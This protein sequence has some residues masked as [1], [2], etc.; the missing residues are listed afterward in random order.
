MVTNGARPVT[1][2]EG[3]DSVCMT[4]GSTDVETGAGADRVDAT[5]AAVGVTADL[6]GGSDIFLGSAASDLVRAGDEDDAQALLPW[7]VDDIDTGA[8]PDAVV[9]GTVI[10]PAQ[11]NGDSVRLGDDA[12]SVTVRGSVPAVLGGGA[13]R[14][15]I[16]PESRVRGDWVVDARTG[17]ISLEGV[18]MPAV[19]SFSTWT[20]TGLSWDTLSFRGGPDKDVVDVTRGNGVVKDGPF[21]ARMGPGKDTIYARSRDT[22][23]FNGGPGDDTL[24]I[25]AKGT[26]QQGGK[27]IAADLAS[28]SFKLTGYDKVRIPSI[29]NLSVSNTDGARLRRRRAPQPAEDLRLRQRRLRHGRRRPHRG[30]G[31]QELLRLRRSGHRR[32]RQRR[33]RQSARQHQPGPPDRRPRPGQGGRR[34]R[35]GRLSG[36]APD[37]LRALSVASAALA[38][39][40]TRVLDHHDEQRDAEAGGDRAD[41]RPLVLV[42]HRAAADLAEALAEPDRADQDHQAGD[43]QAER[44][45]QRHESS[46]LR[47]L[48]V[49]VIGS[50]GTNSTIRGYL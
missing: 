4:N 40:A 14:N 29:E 12:D 11:P 48:P 24:V 36:R 19:S 39:L 42:G 17:V 23:P 43:A 27:T 30:R 26:T 2:L 5:T 13:G 46:R 21:T 18:A 32:L 8:G 44:P 49:A 7:G 25:E 28:D 41:E 3:D 45:A 1:T 35:P 22:G 10:E 20:L 15:E 50:D 34:G 31:R 37:P 6:G 38:V 33:R 47:I 16:A 9:T